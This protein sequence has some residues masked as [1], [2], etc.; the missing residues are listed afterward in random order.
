MV[1]LIEEGGK[2]G[3]EFTK[4]DKIRLDFICHLGVEPRLVIEVKAEFVRLSGVR[5]ILDCRS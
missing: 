1:F 3:R 4:F 5:D 2:K